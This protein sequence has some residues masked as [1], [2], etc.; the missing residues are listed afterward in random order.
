[1]HFVI[2]VSLTSIWVSELSNEND[3]LQCF[4]DWWIY[5]VYYTDFICF[6]WKLEAKSANYI[7]DDKHNSVLKE[8]VGANNCNNDVNIFL[9]VKEFSK[10]NFKAV[11]A[12]IV[13]FI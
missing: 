3:I 4:P 2:R 8:K 1:M 5:S 13:V 12:A 7:I 9:R 11:K 10:G 6:L